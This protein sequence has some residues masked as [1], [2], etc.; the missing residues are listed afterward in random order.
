MNLYRPS[1][2]DGYPISA[3]MS[4]RGQTT[5]FPPY[6]FSFRKL[7]LISDE[8]FAVHEASLNK[9]IGHGIG[10]RIIALQQEH[11]S[12]IISAD[13]M[14]SDRGDGLYTKS[15]QVTISVSL[16]DCCGILIVDPMQKVLMALHSG[17]RGTKAEIGPKGVDLLKQTYNSK[18]EDLLIWLTPCA[19]KSVYEVGEE[20]NDYFPGHVYTS[21]KGS[22][23]LD[24]QGAIMEG[25]LNRGIKKEHLE[26]SDVCTI[27][28]ERFHS[29]RRD[30]DQGRNVAFITFLD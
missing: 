23:T 19:G 13:D 17:W 24:L 4:M 16:A 2:F 29:Y 20:F 5:E 6:G 3:G 21:K 8:Q 7:P 27:N 28:D 18:P 12:Q 30:G 26:I 14:H 10:K 11:G 1:I 25:L 22:F 15:H 9:T